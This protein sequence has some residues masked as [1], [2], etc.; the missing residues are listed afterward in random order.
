M[1]RGC[2]VLAIWVQVACL[3]FTLFVGTVPALAAVTEYVVPTGPLITFQ[4]GRSIEAHI[5]RMDQRDLIIQT[6]N[7][8]SQ[9][10]LRSTV[11]SV[12]FETVTGERIVGELVGWTPG[13]YQIA[14]P[15]AAIKIYCAMPAASVPPRLAIVPKP[16]VAKK[17]TSKT[18]EAVAGS[19]PLDAGRGDP[20]AI[21]AVTAAPR[22]TAIESSATNNVIDTPDAAAVPETGLSIQV[23]VE[24]SR[25]NGPPVAFN[26]ALSKPSDDPVVLIYA[27][28]DGTAVNGEDYEANRGVVLIKP[29]E[30]SARIEAAVIDD[31]EQEEQEH[32]QLFLTVD[33]TVAVVENGQIIATI[34]DDD[35]S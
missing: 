7:G 31:A 34:D 21:A 15:D 11:E 5:M 33:P 1:Q 17:S 28:I 26:I 10:L 19:A 23:S 8:R 30:Q 18:V 27:T 6:G 29:G 32:L 13:V 16:A 35:Q 24:H 9:T 22:K 3:A 25:E 20:Q 4:D 2:S 14:T 12:A